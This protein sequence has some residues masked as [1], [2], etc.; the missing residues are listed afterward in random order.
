MCFSYE[1]SLIAFPLAKLV[2]GYGAMEVTILQNIQET[3]CVGTHIGKSHMIIV[4]PVDVNHVVTQM[5]EVFFRH[6]N[7]GSSALVTGTAVLP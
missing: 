6:S 1:D 5:F 2:S 3:L 4:P 7:I